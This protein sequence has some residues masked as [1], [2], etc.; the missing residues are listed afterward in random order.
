LEVIAKINPQRDRG[1]GNRKYQA[2]LAGRPIVNT[3][4]EATATLDG[5]NIDDLGEPE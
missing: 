3:L 2:A 5:L 1:D 4:N